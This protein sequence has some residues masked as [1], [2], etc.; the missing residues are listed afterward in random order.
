MS[1]SFCCLLRLKGCGTQKLLAVRVG[2][3]LFLVFFLQD[4][5]LQQLG[6]YLKCALVSLFYADPASLTKLIISNKFGLW[7]GGSSFSNNGHCCEGLFLQA[8]WLATPHLSYY[9]LQIIRNHFQLRNLNHPEMTAV[10]KVVHILLVL[11]YL[12]HLQMW[13][14]FF[15]IL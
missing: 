3:K 11:F 6:M 15:N 10:L 12:C 9:I 14:V 2:R 5:N 1:I 4:G 8:R 13:N 7:T